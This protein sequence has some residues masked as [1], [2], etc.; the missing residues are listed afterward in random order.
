MWESSSGF[1]ILIGTCYNFQCKEIT[2]L[3]VRVQRSLLYVREDRDEY[4][5][6]YSDWFPRWR[7]SKKLWLSLQ[8]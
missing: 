7:W 1:R 3:T 2:I 8:N 5:S 6:H 4:L